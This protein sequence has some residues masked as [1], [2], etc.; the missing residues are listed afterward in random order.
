MRM[1]TLSAALIMVLTAGNAF[2]ACSLTKGSTLTAVVPH[3]EIDTL[4]SNASAYASK[5]YTSASFSN[6]F[7]VG[8]FERLATCDNGELMMLEVPLE[9][10]DSGNAFKTG[11]DN[12][13][14]SVSGRYPLPSGGAS[15]AIVTTNEYS[16]SDVFTSTGISD[17]MIFSLQVPGGKLASGTTDSLVLWRLKTSDGKVIAEYKITPLTVN[18]RACSV[19]AYDSEVSFDELTVKKLAEPLATSGEQTFN[20]NIACGTVYTPTIMF[21]GNTDSEY[22]SVFTNQSGEG[23]AQGV[24]IQ[25]LWNNNIITPGKAFRLTGI[26]TATDFKFSSRVFSLTQTTTT[27][28]IDIPVVF[29]LGY[30]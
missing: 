25:L 8:R 21:S 6:L 29:T 30:D 24:G 28:E 23:Y 9:L 20:I 18:V 17:T 12:L 27:G 10:N 15:E 5:T 16:L 7:G 26:T 2:A 19:N 14:F 1:K 4:I 22:T 3:S 13:Y 11:V